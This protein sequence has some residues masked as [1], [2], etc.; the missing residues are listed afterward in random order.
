MYQIDDIYAASS[1]PAL[2]TDNVGAPGYFQGSNAVIG[3]KATRLRFWW[4]NMVQEELRAIVL[5]AGITLVKGQNN[6]VL[7]AIQAFLGNYLP[8]AGGHVTGP[9]TIDGSVVASTNLTVDNELGVQGSASVVG[10]ATVGG[11]LAVGNTLTVSSN[12]TASG[13]LTAGNFYTSNYHLAGPTNGN[14][15]P[16]QSAATGASMSGGQF[17][18]YN[19]SGSSG[20]FGTAAAGDLVDFW[21][22]NVGTISIQGKIT[23]TGTGVV[24]G[25]TSDY[26]LKQDVVPLTGALD[27]IGHLTAKRFAFKGSPEVVVDGFL[28]HEAAEVA[29]QAVAG[30]KD[31]VD[32]NGAIVPQTMD[33]TALVPVLWAAVQELKALVDKQAAQIAVLATKA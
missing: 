33:A 23:T 19:A 29:P 14:L 32:E 7:T 27:R 12:V 24:Y 13:F 5:A 8:L 18:A 11:T 26:R 10:S 21:V 3:Q 6:Q 30:T 17:N 4:F 28:A 22:G 2:P 25:T 31:A 9:V 16:C 20:Q 1:L 15:T